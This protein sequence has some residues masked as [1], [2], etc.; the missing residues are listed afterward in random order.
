MRNIFNSN[1]NTIMQSNVQANNI[2]IYNTIY[3]ELKILNVDSIH[4]TTT[5]NDFFE[6][7]RFLH[8]IDHS[9]N[10]R[11]RA[12][13]RYKVDKF[14]NDFGRRTLPVL[15]PTILNKLPVDILNTKNI[16]KRKKLI[17]HFFISS[18]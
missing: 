13:K 8:I 14:S 4:N 3:K 5:A 18:Q 9:H 2:N 10:T 7:N 1:T 6:D 15:L 11:R 17:K 16:N 12:Q